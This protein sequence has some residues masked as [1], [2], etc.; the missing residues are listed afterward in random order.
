MLILWLSWENEHNYS[1]GYISSNA[2]KNE[3]E[4][5]HAIIQE[6]F[7][8][9]MNNT[10]LKWDIHFYLSFQSL[11]VTLWW[12]LWHRDENEGAIFWYQWLKL[13]C[14]IL[15]VLF[16]MWVEPVNILISRY[17]RVTQYFYLHYDLQ[18]DFLMVII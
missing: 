10:V 4:M 2:K 1:S 6:I 17:I 5:K 15:S 18:I 16:A 7:T 9:K 8:W 14:R 3:C 11:G 13:I 12:R